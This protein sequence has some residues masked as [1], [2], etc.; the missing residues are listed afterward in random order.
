[1][2][3]ET[4]LPLHTI[5]LLNALKTDVELLKQDSNFIRTLFEKVDNT[6]S[7]INNQH[8][9]MSDRTHQLIDNNSRFNREEI[10]DIC[11]RLDKIEESLQNRIRDIENSLKTDLS[12]LTTKVENHVTSENTIISY[13]K[14]LGWLLAGMGAIITWMASNLDLVKKFIH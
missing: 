7:R 9:I 2:D 4:Q 11:N 3:K 12:K 10:D 1:M 13:A 6:I 5:E 14:K 8:D